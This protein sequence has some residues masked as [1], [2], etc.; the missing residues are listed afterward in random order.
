MSQESIKNPHTSDTS[1]SPELIDRLP[2]FGRV[3]FKG[4]Y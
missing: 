2:Q 3:K 1:F 4:I